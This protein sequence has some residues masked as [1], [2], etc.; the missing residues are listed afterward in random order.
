MAY[1]R[2]AGSDKT[3]KSYLDLKDVKYFKPSNEKDGNYAVD[4]IPFVIKSKRHPAVKRGAVVGVD[5]AYKLDVLVHFGVGP[6]KKA[7]VCPTTF[8]LPCP[9][10]EAAEEVKRE[11]GYQSEDFKALKPKKR[12]LYNLVDVDNLKDG[13]QVYDAS[14]AWFEEKM[15]SA[16]EGRGK[17]KGL[18]ILPFDDIEAGYTV[19]FQ[20]VIKST[21][22]GKAAEPQNFVFEPRGEALPKSL[23]NKA[24]DFTEFLKLSTY[25]EIKAIF[26][27]VDDTLEDD[28]APPRRERAVQ[29]DEPAPRRSRYATEEDETPPV[30][31]VGQRPVEAEDAPPP[32]RASRYAE[33]DESPL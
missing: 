25:E 11:K 20:T 22:T 32:R 15:V 4:I 12:T 7:V 1:D 31:T 3:D 19:E 24:V 6:S 5:T 30:R 18:P 8:G 16:A 10:C 23:I 14:T 9:I 13:V 2:Y 33:A 21:G 29:E 17:K 28:D 27:G 26:H